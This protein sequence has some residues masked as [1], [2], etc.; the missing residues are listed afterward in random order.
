MEEDGL[1][2]AVRLG[3]GRGDSLHREARVRRG[4]RLQMD[5]DPVGA[6]VEHLF[7]RRRARRRVADLE[8]GSDH[9][10]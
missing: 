6:L 1:L 9:E 10:A 5:L 4:R 7:R 8:R 2:A 3:Y